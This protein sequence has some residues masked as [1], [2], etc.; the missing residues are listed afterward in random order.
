MR[1]FLVAAITGLLSTA[2]I[3]TGPVVASITVTYIDLFMEANNHIDTVDKLDKEFADLLVEGDGYS[4]GVPLAS[5][6]IEYDN[7][8]LGGAAVLSVK[9][10]AQAGASADTDAQVRYHI[11]FQVDGEPIDYSYSGLHEIVNE[12]YNVTYHARLWSAIQSY[13]YIFSNSWHAGDGS[14]VMD[15]SFT[16]TLMPGAY[17]FSV[18][19]HIEDDHYHSGSGVARILATSSLR[20]GNVPEPTTLLVWSLLGLTVSGGIGRRLRSVA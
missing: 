19:A 6:S 2:L 3:T 10:A 14:P 16:G 20:L 5:A 7:K 18:T 8:I 17:W 9:S 1:H 15:E 4:V 13:P 11:K 12:N